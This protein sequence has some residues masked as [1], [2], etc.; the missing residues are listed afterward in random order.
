VSRIAHSPCAIL[1]TNPK[2]AGN[3]DGPKTASPK[4][5]IHRIQ[6]PRTATV[7]QVPHV[8]SAAAD[9]LGFYSK[10]ACH[11]EESTAADDESL[12]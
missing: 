1:L 6:P 7:T 4:L 12:P 9:D 5:K 8:P 2:V 3:V 10:D 11:P